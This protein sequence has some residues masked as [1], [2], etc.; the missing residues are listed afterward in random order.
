[1]KKVVLLI[2]AVVLTMTSCK[3]DRTCTCT[4]TFVS[5]TDNGIPQP[6]YVTSLTM[7]EK[8]T[9]VKKNDAHCN[10]GEETSTKT[11]VIGG[12]SHTYID[13]TKIDGKLN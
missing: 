5:S 10:S 4:A 11:E 3:K 13:V 8:I 1:M 2:A 7:S 9:K 6:M 12:V